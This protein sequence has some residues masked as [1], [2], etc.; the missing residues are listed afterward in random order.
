M[1]DP[2]N[3]SRR[4]L[5]NGEELSFTTDRTPRRADKYHPK[6]L[7]EARE[8]LTPQL[9]DVKSQMESLEPALRADRVIIEA[10]VWANYLANSWFPKQL[11]RRLDLRPLGSRIIRD[12]VKITPVNGEQLSL[13]KSYLLSADMQGIEIMISLLNG[14]ASNPGFSKAAEE[15]Q[16]FS[17]IKVSRAID[18]E[19][20]TTAEDLFSYE[21]VLHPDP[22][23]STSS[24]RVGASS[25]IID[26][27]GEL[28]ESVGGNVSSET[29]V[30]D[31]LT[32]LSLKLPP[33]SVESI[34]MFNPLRS[35]SPMPEVFLHTVDGGDTTELDTPDIKGNSAALP[36][37]LVFDGGVD[38]QG[39]VFRGHVTTTD[40]TGRG[41]TA[42]Y[43]EHGSAVT[44]AILYGDAATRGSFG[45]PVARVDHYQVFPS[46]VRQKPTEY[47]WILRNIR[48]VV[49][50]T[51]AKIVNLSL[52]PHVSVNDGE[53]HRWTAVLDKLAFERGVLFI[54]A[55]GNNGME[56]EPGLNRIQ[57]PGDM[58]NGLTVGACD[59]PESQDS[60]DPTDYSAKGPGRP[61]GRI[62]P[63]VL[64]YGGTQ[65][66]GFGRIRANG[67]IH[68]DDHGT[69]YSAPLVTNIVAQLSRELGGRADAPT[70]RALAVHLAQSNGDTH[71]PKHHGYGRL[72]GDAVSLLDCNSHEATVVYQG[73]LART[74]VRAFPLPFPP[75]FAKGDLELSWTIAYSTATDATEAGEYTNAG[76]EVVFR[77]HKE[78]YSMSIENPDGSTRTRVVHTKKDARDI[79]GHLKK[80][81]NISSAPTTRSPKI[82]RFEDDQRELG[83]W[84]TLW[85]SQD[86]I[87]AS[88]MQ[89]PRLEVNH[90]SREGGQ[91]TRDT[92]DIEFSLIVTIRS[93]A[94]K[95]IYDLVVQDFNVLT[96]LP[97]ATP[98]NT[99]VQTTA[100]S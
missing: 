59:T 29:D 45:Q 93:V 18:R 87:R 86:R 9:L 36:R 96:P 32:F 82:T 23:A 97:V 15:L 66:K 79:V 41:L 1:A 62:Q 63:A 83:K 20:P 80:G 78:K 12:G 13:S 37:V 71:D 98:V 61:G 49:S 67:S 57:V 74:E 65:T 91:I 47:P 30:V 8:L 81:W 21:A 44:G 55:A 100:Q 77:P 48:E 7:E 39:T 85:H 16:W 56:V 89:E 42:Q 25:A 2:G 68:H 22:D 46:P 35:L 92:D 73:V 4:I 34:A 38:D 40:L 6:T 60:W 90:L 10:Q 11:T 69:S 95:P 43:A 88:S 58:V 28:V 3:Q 51:N 94:R 50:S 26:K 64:S 14:E 33:Q 19:A 76:L 84:E 52:G 99:V 72:A 75:S 24:Q 5:V 70:L 53:P 31:G 54:N 17:G 27:F